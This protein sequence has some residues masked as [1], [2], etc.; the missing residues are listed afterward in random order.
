[1]IDVV[2]G[3]EQYVGARLLD[4]FDAKAP[5][6]RRLWCASLCLTLREMLEAVEAQRAG[7][8]VEATVGALANSAQMLVGLDP[9]V[10]RDRQ[11]LQA[12]LKGKPRFEGL[13]YHVVATCESSLR[14]RYLARWAAALRITPPPRQEHVARS[15]ASHLLD[16]GFSSDYLH[17]WWRFRLVHQEGQRSLADIVEEADVLARTAP[18]NFKLLAP[19]W[20]ASAG[21]LQSSPDWLMAPQVSEWLRRNRSD[22]SNVRQS[23]GIV[24]EVA[25]L[26]PGAA[27]ER[28][29][30][31]VD[32][33]SARIAV[34]TRR[35]VGFV[36]KVWVEGEREP[37]S[38][39]GHDRGV[40]VRALERENQ[41]LAVGGARGVEA[42][43]ELLSHLQRSS[44]PAAVAGGWAAIEAL[45]SEPNDRGG[46]ADRLAILVACSFPRADLTGLSYALPRSDAEWRKLLDGVVEN[47]ERCHVVAKHLSAGHPPTTSL[48]WS[49]RAAVGRVV[50]I[51]KDPN[52]LL[53]RVQEHAA[54]AFRRLYRQRNLVLHWGKTNA[55]ALRTSLRTA[56]PLVGAGMDRVIHAAYVDGISPLELVARARVSLASIGPRTSNHCVDLLQ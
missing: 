39:R 12:A 19:V 53:G 44:P 20:S 9:A 13:D 10:H 45:L 31:Y 4:F 17:R 11:T 23:G 6:H 30:E 15:I 35:V 37:Y 47:R 28:A 14:E 40:W 29:S 48:P 27:A 42:A 50:A 33:L 49:D 26:D 51:L 34:G 43:I 41:L 2:N 55:V 21:S 36:D 5:W 24:F 22:P 16:V 7:V 46:A 1:M 3:Y 18:K 56:A 38:T 54:A 8:L 32:A 52:S 25:A